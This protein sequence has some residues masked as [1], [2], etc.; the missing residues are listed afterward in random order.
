MTRASTSAAYGDLHRYLRVLAGQ[1]P[2]G[3]WL[4]VRYGIG[5]GAMGRRFIPASRTAN[6]ARLILAQAARSDVYCGVLLRTQRAGGRGAVAGSHLAFMEIDTPDARERLERF[7]CPPTML[8]ASGSPGHLH[9]YWQ[10]STP[11]GVHE[12][13]AA[14]RQLAYAIGGDLASVDAARILRPPGSWNHKHTPPT[15]VRLLELHPARGYQLAELTA[16]LSGPPTPRREAS[17]VHRGRPHPHDRVLLGIPASDYVTQLTGLEANRSGKVC[18]PFHPDET[19]SLQLYGDNSFYCFGCHAGGSIYDFA[20]RLWG[21]Q[22]KGPAFIELRQR[23][24][25]E[26]GLKTA[27]EIRGTAPITRT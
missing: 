11:I 1:H 3:R 7:A 18:C 27:R 22:T 5:G 25:E 16:G 24:L 9:A 2:A 20:A 4:E 6:A 17:V 15:P 12:L 10:L 14:N 23:L 21:Q 8:V 19:P 26:L 13:E